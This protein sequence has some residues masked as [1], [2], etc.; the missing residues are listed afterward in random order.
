ME[1]ELTASTNCDG[2][3]ISDLHASLVQD[4]LDRTANC[5][6]VVASGP[7]PRPCVIKANML[8]R[9]VLIYAFKTDLSCHLGRRG[10][11]AE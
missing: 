3:P 4:R 10:A 8:H 11:G 6:L 1:Q 9:F 7:F 2:S 5:S